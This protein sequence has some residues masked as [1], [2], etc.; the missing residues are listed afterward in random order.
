MSLSSTSN[1]LL[2][3]REG[4]ANLFFV[5]LAPPPPSDLGDPPPPSPLF[6][7]PQRLTYGGVP[8]EVFLQIMHRVRS[9]EPNSED[10]DEGDEGDEGSGGE[11]D[12]IRA[13]HVCLGWR[14]AILGC[15][16]L[17]TELEGVKVASFGGVER[18]RAVAE[19]SKGNLRTLTLSFACDSE[20]GLSALPVVSMLRQILREVSTR[21]SARKLK[22]L[23]LDLKPFRYAEDIEAPFNCIVV[24][25]QFAEFSAVNLTTFHISSY[26]DRFPSGAPFFFALP[27]LRNLSLSSQQYDPPPDSRLPDFFQTLATIE[28]A[29]VSAVRLTSLKLC[30]TSLMDGNYPSLPN[31]RK[32]Q[33][34][35]VKCSNLYGLLSKCAGTLELLKLLG[36]SADPSNRFLPPPP[37]GGTKDLPPVL[38]LPRLAD[39]QLAGYNTP[40]LY[41]SPTQTTSHFSTSTPVLKRCSFSSQPLFDPDVSDEGDPVDPLQSLTTESL[42]TL[43]R[44]SPWLSKLDLTGTSVTEA[45]LIASLPFAGSALTALRIGETPAATDS[46]IDRLSNL[47]PQLRWLDVWA[48]PGMGM[49]MGMGGE[50]KVSVQALARLAMRLKGLSP[51][52]RWLSEWSVTFVTTNPHPSDSPTLST[53]RH[54]L[55]GFL[56][57]LSPSQL[58]HLV[59]SSLVLNS[60]PNAMSYASVKAEVLALGTPPA[61]ITGDGSP[62]GVS[63]KGLGSTSA[64]TGDA[65]ALKKKKQKQQQLLLRPAAPQNIVDSASSALKAWQKRR[66]EEWALEWIGKEEGVK[67]EW[68]VGCGDPSCGCGKGHPG[69]G[70]WNEAFEGLGDEDEE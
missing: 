14:R 30:G 4:H 61:P 36:V 9:D 31:L 5:S 27:S 10:D 41:T 58:E 13:S 45:M 42:S 48:R 20:M 12:L 51:M 64:A 67:V 24:A 40:S 57:S 46:L 55:R 39:L 18:V 29:Q 35:S 32:L 1:T 8:L 25:A 16:R 21:D 33:L 68:G 15:G 19:R 22:V 63:T 11:L 47:M 52:R 28:G 50:Q 23:K 56:T 66:E 65:M 2:G 59:S 26:L 70:E 49:G 54:T 44:N 6:G 53:L 60:P 17:W 3:P 69:W 7:K 34:C 62:F 37:V 43:F 38:E